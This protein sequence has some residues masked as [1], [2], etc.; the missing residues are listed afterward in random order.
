MRLLQVPFL[1]PARVRA[2]QEGVRLQ[3]DQHSA[4][5]AGFQ[6]M[7]CSPSATF[8]SCF[9]DWSTSATSSK[10]SAGMF[11]LMTPSTQTAFCF[12]MLTIGLVLLGHHLFSASLAGQ[13]H[14]VRQL[15]RRRADPFQRDLDGNIPL[16]W[17][18]SSAV[19][20]M[21]VDACPESA[22]VRNW[23]G[24]MAEV[25]EEMLAPME[26]LP[27]GRS[28]GSATRSPL[29]PTQED[30]LLAVQEE[31]V[32][33]LSMLYKRLPRGLEA[34]ALRHL[35][36]DERCELQKLETIIYKQV[37]DFIQDNS[38]PEPR[39]AADLAQ[40]CTALPYNFAMWVVDQV[41]GFQ[42]S[43]A[44]S[45]L[46]AEKDALAWLLLGLRTGAF[47][48]RLDLVPK[49]EKDFMKHRQCLT[50]EDL[51]AAVA[52]LQASSAS[53]SI[54]SIAEELVLA[55]RAATT[56][57]GLKVTCLQA[58]S[59]WVH[60]ALLWQRYSQAAPE[61]MATL[62][63]LL[64]ANDIQVQIRIPP[65][66]SLKST[67][68][69][70][71][72]LWPSM[73]HACRMLPGVLV[74]DILAAEVPLESAASVRATHNHLCSWRWR[75]HGAELMWT[76]NNFDSN[77]GLAPD[78]LQEGILLSSSAGPVLVNLRLSLLPKLSRPAALFLQNVVSGDLLTES[79]RP[80]WVLWLHLEMALRRAEQTQ[81]L[82]PLKAALARA[83]KELRNLRF[84]SFA[85]GAWLQR[86]EELSKR[87]LQMEDQ[88]RSCRDVS[89]ALQD[90]AAV[91]QS[92]LNR[93]S[94]ATS[95]LDAC[96]MAPLEMEQ[97]PEPV[98]RPIATNCLLEQY[99]SQVSPSSPSFKT[100][101]G[102]LAHCRL[103][104]PQGML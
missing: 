46:P 44:T 47:P 9:S 30:L 56:M 18:S 39:L 21:L 6:I 66:P 31:D 69:K 12:P 1:Q 91:A 45:N 59:A 13:D 27:N 101:I 52:E 35:L 95:T 25:L 76:L 87:V 79:L 78:G 99:L 10:H 48:T 17:A 58:A 8:C 94:Y 28:L 53:S 89:D 86:L 55:V 2:A 23:R 103:Q 49:G 77:L 98:P 33:R 64:E 80:F 20:Q 26:A 5:A 50:E 72:K 71:L 104:D 73:Q 14:A 62:R 41:S 85:G 4:L 90:R 92:C 93:L 54:R 67:W 36:E 74:C 82:A 11:R 61:A 16:H 81:R 60:C 68:Q 96:I 7:G 34:L 88:E 84:V 70:A 75:T 19:A 40:A 51:R 63:R 29:L 3:E 83:Y 22:A 24:Q 32:T 42:I 100:K 65:L 102:S 57:Q 38:K 43:L 97:W 37:R 15:L